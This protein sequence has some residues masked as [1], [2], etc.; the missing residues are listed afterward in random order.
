MG[1]IRRTDVEAFKYHMLSTAK[2]P[3]AQEKR[4]QS[5]NNALKDIQAIWNRGLKEGWITGDNPAQAGMAAVSRTATATFINQE[6]GLPMAP[7]LRMRT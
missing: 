6:L 4:K 3:E 1:D 7:S 2:D 5:I